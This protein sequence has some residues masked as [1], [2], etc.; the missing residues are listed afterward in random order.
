MKNLLIFVDW[1][2]PG[3]KAGGQIQSCANLTFALKDEMNVYVV[4]RDR[5]LGDNRSYD[6]VTSDSWQQAEKGLH[7]IYVS[8][9]RITYGNMRQIIQKVN[10]D[11]IYL[12]SMF[13]FRFTILP[14]IAANWS[15]IK[16]KIVLAPRGMLHKGALQFK[17]NK[18]Q[19]FLKL[20]KYLGFHK[21]VVFHVTDPVEIVD[22][23]AIFGE[24][25]NIEHVSDFPNFL[26]QPQEIVSKKPGQLDCIFV[27]RISPKK[28]LQFVLSL[29][30]EVAGKISLTIVGPVESEK[31]WEECKKQINT[32]PP[33][34]KVEYIGAVPNH[35]LANI[36]RQHHLFVLPTHGENFGHVIF[37]SLVNGRPVLI[38][39]QTPWR[40]LQQKKVG[41]DLNLNDPDSFA[42]VIRE[43][44]SWDQ[45][46][47]NEHC[48][49]SWQYAG[50]YISGSS[51]KKQ[52]L[53]LFGHKF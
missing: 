25:T 45:E 15:G 12:N 48:T 52:Y 6:N 20:F 32:L 8:P 22:T 17:I 2:I 1:F 14:L 24:E 34:I 30:K 31:Y 49:A 4:T 10:P 53:H 3:Y 38:S 19:S 23:R 27:S 46:Q 21:K 13:S 26:Q 18:K 37:E 28:N 33:N 29:L 51:L 16:S 44:V 40:N 11:C 7:I 9:S 50:N 42:N 41:W 5:D 43:I 35:L 36:Y 39:D 47:F